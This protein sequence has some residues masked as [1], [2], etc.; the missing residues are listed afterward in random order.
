[1]SRYSIPCSCRL[2]SASLS[3]AARRLAGR[4]S[5]RRG[6]NKVKPWRAH[7]LLRCVNNSSS[8]LYFFP[9]PSSPSA[10]QRDAA[11][12]G[13]LEGGNK[14]KKGRI[15]EAQNP[16]AMS[17]LSRVPSSL[18]TAPAIQAEQPPAPPPSS[19]PPPTS[20]S[21]A[22]GIGPGKADGINIFFPFFT[23]EIA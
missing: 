8:L 12:R 9:V 10:A 18:L 22:N 2:L 15:G 5:E 19:S 11:T 14:K 17:C 20:P 16:R 7:S 21:A 23:G 3:G 6:R 13:W 1:M 4:I